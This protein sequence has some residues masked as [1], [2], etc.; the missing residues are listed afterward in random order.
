[1]QKILVA[2]RGEIAIRVMR[3]AREIGIPT[4]AVYSEADADSPHVRAADEALAIGAAEPSASYLNFE[5][6]FEAARAARADA[7][8][9]G[10]G[11]LA[12]N[13]AFARACEERGLLF[14]GSTAESIRLLGSKTESRRA[15]E[16]AGVPLIPGMRSR[17]ESLAAFESEA[18]KVGYPVLIKASG[19]GGGKGMRVV[20]DP[21]AL[22]EAVEAARREALSAFGDDSVYL[23]K[24]IEEPRHVEFQIFGDRHGN[25]VHLFERE[26]S[27]QRRHQK[28]IEESPSVALD[29]DLR[30]RMGETAVRVARAAAY[31]N[32]GTV[33]FLLDKTGH[34]YFLEVNTRIQVEHPVTEMLVGVDLVQAQI[35]VAA[36]EPL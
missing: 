32:A 36:G 17:G 20:R 33:E 18:E 16:A 30:R 34:F 25:T 7:I 31:T 8:H 11:F 27:I 35:R 1:M 22:K 6:I 9:P 24:L 3:A 5:R 29:Q 23:E 28:I 21:S 10:Y 13:H 26:C 2:N 15:M 14:I 12:E 4:V 19:G